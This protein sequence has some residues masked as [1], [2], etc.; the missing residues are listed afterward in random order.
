MPKKMMDLSEPY[1]HLPLDV[2]Q[3]YDYVWTK[4]KVNK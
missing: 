4:V 3:A 2:R 1:I